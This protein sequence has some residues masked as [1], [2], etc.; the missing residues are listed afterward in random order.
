MLPELRKKWASAFAAYDRAPTSELRVEL[1]RLKDEI[2]QLQEMQLRYSPQ[3]QSHGF[4][5]LCLR[6]P[7]R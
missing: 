2:A 7:R 3:Q 6:A 4:V 1:A 5:W